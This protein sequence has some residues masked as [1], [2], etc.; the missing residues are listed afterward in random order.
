[1]YAKFINFCK[2]KQ[3]NWVVN[4]L[5]SDSL[6]IEETIIKKKFYSFK[7]YELFYN[8]IKIFHKSQ[9]LLEKKVI[10][11]FPSIKPLLIIHA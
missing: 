9:K 5:K 7:E 2:N 11:A 10:T 1:M 3:I 4:A 6:F 8:N